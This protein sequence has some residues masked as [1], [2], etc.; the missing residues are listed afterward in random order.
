MRIA[1]RINE[2]PEK[3]ASL[4]VVGKI[5]IGEKVETTPGKSRPV[6]LDYF[7]PDAP[8]QY[9]R[10]FSEYYGGKPT[11]ITVVF[12]SNDMNEVCRNFYELRDGEGKRLAYGDGNT[13]FVATRQGDNTVKDVV[14]TPENPQSW[15]DE[16]EKRAGGKW[17]ERLILRFAIPA[18]PLLGVWEFSTHGSGSTI[19]NIIGTIDTMQQMAGRI[20]GIPFDLIIE[21]VKSDKAGSKS[22]YPVVKIIPN[23]SPESAEIVRGLPMQLG[24]ILTQKKIAQLSTGEPVIIENGVNETEFEEIESSPKKTAKERAELEFKKFRLE[25]V[26]D[27]TLAAA[28]ISKMAEKEVQFICAELLGDAAQRM[29]FS[30]DKEKKR[31]TV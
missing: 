14:V 16:T 20:A 7:K 19:P 23:I 2:Q 17:R 6:S 9:A 26:D 13:F 1:R 25:T 22:V 3:T 8:E 30:F 21:K 5:K 11:K 28:M 29:G 12:L 27:Y 31:Y 4:G 15:M 18:L 24:A 10:F